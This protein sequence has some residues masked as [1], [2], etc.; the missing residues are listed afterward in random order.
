M[1]APLVQALL[2][3][4]E[5]I[6]GLVN[7]GK[8]KR[9]AEQ[10][11]RDRPVYKINPNVDSEVKLNQS[12][13]S[14]GMGAEA[15]KAYDEGLDKDLSSSIGAILKSGGSTNSLGTLYDNSVVG[16]QKL[17]M[18]RE[19]IRMNQV[20]N[21]IGS[22]RNQTNEGDKAFQFN[23]YAPWADKAAANAGARQGAENQ[24]WGGLGTAASGVM[25]NIEGNQAQKNYAK[26]LQ[27]LS[28][29]N[30]NNGQMLDQPP[31]PTTSNRTQPVLSNNPVPQANQGDLNNMGDLY[32]INSGN[33]IWN[34]NNRPI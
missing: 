19:G 12:E 34:L 17:A 33:P 25:N 5:A 15:T 2:G 24:I 4:V 3:G 1:G 28:G 8:A 18:M 7:K 32:N 29:N 27:I 23:Q 30:G 10:L 31:Y 22:Y 9:E 14:N 26:Y 16:R 6:A 21:L 13:L 11:A 20:N